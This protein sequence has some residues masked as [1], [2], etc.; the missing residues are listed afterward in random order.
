MRAEWFAWM[1]AV[2]LV[3]LAAANPRMTYWLLLHFA[4]AIRRALARRRHGVNP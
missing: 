2:L 1:A 4:A 3:A